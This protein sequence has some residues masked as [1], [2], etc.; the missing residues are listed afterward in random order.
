V[1]KRKIFVVDDHEIVRFGIAQLVGRQP[2]LEVCG[3]ANNSPA[4]LTGIAA[5]SPDLAIIDLSLKESAGLDLVKNLHA[6]RPALPILVLSMYEES[7]Y[8][9]MCLRAGAMG[10]LMKEQGM[11]KL[12]EAIYRVL[13]GKIYA[14]ENLSNAL[15]QQ[16]VHPSLSADQSP[17]KRLSLRELE[18]LRLIGHW[19][20]T[21]QIAKEL[22][23]SVKTVEYYRDQ[24]KRKLNLKTGIELVQYAVQI[25]GRHYP[26]IS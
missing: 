12:L 10:Y 23:L 13:S 17:L 6:T 15:L 21:A 24:L 3:E 1:A 4:A 5:T 16:R 18:V 7:I 26:G 14:S 9:E 19:K 25:A 20:T 22:N 11:S 8:G 2:D